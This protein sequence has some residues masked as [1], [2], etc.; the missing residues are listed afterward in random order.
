MRVLSGCVMA[1]AAMLWSAIALDRQ[2]RTLHV[3]ADLDLR[4]R[5]S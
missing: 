5:F 4:G 2:P 1:I 3:V